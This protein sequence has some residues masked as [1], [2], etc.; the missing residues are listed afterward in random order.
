M[1][2]AHLVADG[3]ISRSKL[4]ESLPYRITTLADEITR[5]LSS[6]CQQFG[7]SVGE[8]AVL[9]AV[10]ETPRCTSKA[11]GMRCNIHKTKMSRA[12]ASLEQRNLIL[13]TPNRTDLREA[14]LQLTPQGQNLHAQCAPLTVELLRRLNDA[15]D[16]SDRELLDRCLTRL[17]GMSRRL[18]DGPLDLQTRQRR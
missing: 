8:W 1:S 10:S 15:M 11:I 18:A 4:E 13:R 2:A 12:V 3:T 7:L 14:F 16:A 5:A 6:I 9:V 17:S